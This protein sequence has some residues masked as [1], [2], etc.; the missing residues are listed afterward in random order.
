P[1]RPRV[2]GE[3]TKRC[4][5]VVLDEPRQDRRGIRE[6]STDECVGIDRYLLSEIDGR[7]ARQESSRP[8]RGDRHLA[9]LAESLHGILV[10]RHEHAVSIF[11]RSK[12][13]QRLVREAGHGLDDLAEIVRLVRA[14]GLS[15]LKAEPTREAS[16]PPNRALL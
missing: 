10:N 6:L 13:D 1:P 9:A 5:G 2:P 14:D 12:L 7:E 8:F 3:E 16:E 11:A 15:S 4:G